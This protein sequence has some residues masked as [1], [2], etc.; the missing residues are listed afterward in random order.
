LPKK[1]DEVLN[2]IGG[3]EAAL[4]EINAAYCAPGFFERTPLVE[5]DRLQKERERLEAR[6]TELTAQ[7]ESLEAEIAALE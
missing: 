2:Q 6:L 3:V 1:R 7:W 5:V 4:A